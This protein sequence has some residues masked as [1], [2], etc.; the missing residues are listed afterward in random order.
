MDWR[1]IPIPKRM[2]AL[3]RD[4]RGLPVPFIVLRD[5]DG[6]PHFT[7]NDSQRQ[8]KCIREKRCPICGNRLDKVMWFVGG[9]LSAF[10]DAGGAGNRQLLRGSRPPLRC[11]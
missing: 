2:R 5:T 9:P 7:I 3:Q 6:R 11:V 4:R 1:S 8:L 10:H